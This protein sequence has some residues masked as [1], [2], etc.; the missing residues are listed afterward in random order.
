[1]KLTPFLILGFFFTFN[2]ISSLIQTNSLIQTLPA[3]ENLSLCV[4]RLLEYQALQGLLPM[5]VK[6]PQTA[7]SSLNPAFEWFQGQENS[8]KGEFAR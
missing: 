7:S 5:L 6:G 1:M 3:A 8:Q 2:E 4:D